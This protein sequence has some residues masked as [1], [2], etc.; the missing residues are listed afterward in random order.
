M[1]EHLKLLGQNLLDLQNMVNNLEKQQ[2]VSL[3]NSSTEVAAID[4]R[5]ERTPWWCP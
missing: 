4:L 3:A 2:K 1:P 5:I